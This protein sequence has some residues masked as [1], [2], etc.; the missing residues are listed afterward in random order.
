MNRGVAFPY[1]VSKMCLCFLVLSLTQIFSSSSSSSFL[2]NWFRAWIARDLSSYN[3]IKIKSKENKR[4]YSRVRVFVYGSSI[5]TFR[6]PENFIYVY[7]KFNRG[8]ILGK[9][10]VVITHV[11]RKQHTLRS[12]F[13]NTTRSLSRC[14]PR[15]LVAHSLLA[16][17][18]VDLKVFRLPPFLPQVF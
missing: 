9:E 18:P 17:R 16:R 10:R 7:M 3:K 14:R 11:E 13:T 6:F 15:E 2:P 12:S 4:Y 5:L 8:V 1:C